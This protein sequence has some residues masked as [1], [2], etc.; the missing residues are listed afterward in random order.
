MALTRLRGQYKNMSR[1]EEKLRLAALWLPRETMIKW[2]N[3]D[4]LL[5][6]Y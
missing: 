1:Q 5:K 3:W 2:F 6:G 4:P